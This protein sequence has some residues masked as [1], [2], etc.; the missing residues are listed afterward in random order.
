MPPMSPSELMVFHFRED[1]TERRSAIDDAIADASLADE[2]RSYL[3]AA[4]GG[5]TCIIASLHCA[6]N[7]LRET[8]E[9]GQNAEKQ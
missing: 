9:A 4:S 7:E 6:L 1:L 3:V 2:A 8:R 5:L